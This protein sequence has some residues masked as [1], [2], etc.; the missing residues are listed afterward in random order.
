MLLLLLKYC[1]ITSRSCSSLFSVDADGNEL[2]TFRWRF[3]KNYF[4]KLPKRLGSLRPRSRKGEPLV[5]VLI[6]MSML[7]PMLTLMLV[8]FL[9]VVTLLS[10]TPAGDKCLFVEISSPMDRPLSS[11]GCLPWGFAHSIQNRSFLSCSGNASNHVCVTILIETCLLPK[12]SILSVT[13]I[14]HW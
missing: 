11:K 6:M 3:T 7:L 13:R 12:S 14:K 8:G 4:R 1:P 5:F 2:R 9:M 10:S